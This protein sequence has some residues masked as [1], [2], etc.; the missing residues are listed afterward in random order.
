LQIAGNEHFENFHVES[1]CRGNISAPFAG[2]H[3]VQP[4]KHIG[5]NF[6]KLNSL[7]VVDCRHSQHQAIP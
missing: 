4:A 5:V 6:V 2:Q 7:S 3:R 1:L